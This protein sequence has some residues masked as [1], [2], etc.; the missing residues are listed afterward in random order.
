MGH[1]GPGTETVKGET[2]QRRE[3]P[4]TGAVEDRLLHVAPV[5]ADATYELYTD[6]LGEPYLVPVDPADALWCDSCQ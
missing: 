3:A 1:Q 2:A 5:Q 6:R 4:L